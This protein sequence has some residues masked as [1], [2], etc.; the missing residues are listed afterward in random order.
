MGAVALI[1]MTGLILARRRRARADS[2]RELDQR[3]VRSAMLDIVQGSG[4]ATARLRPFRRQ[5]R[6]MSETLLEFLAIVRGGEKAALVAAFRSL[7]IDD[8]IRH[9][10]T[11]GGKQGRTLA[12]EAI[13]AFPGPETVD[14]LQRL[15]REDRDPEVRIAAVRSLIALDAPPTL[16]D[17][18]SD[19]RIRGVS[20]SLLYLPVVLRMTRLDPEQALAL[21]ADPAISLTARTLIA[22]ALGECGD[23]RAVM[24]LC[25]AASDA[26]RALRIAAVRGLGVL[27]HPAAAAAIVQALDDREWE[28]RS[29]AC[30]AAG[31]IGLTEALP[32]LVQRLTDSE[33][34]V[35]FQAAEAMTRMGPAGLARLRAAAGDDIDVMRRAASMALAENGLTMEP[36]P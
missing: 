27:A 11:R 3:Q 24:P 35:R 17:L 28:V 22:G 25:E 30:E 13:A 14:V 34:W 9:R 10:L 7:N 31:R 29:A 18:I 16:R 19:L 6:L 12:A 32:G 1:W 15:M 20:D 5:A 21:F 33:W 26:D 8:R 2:R 36:A 4:D 23:Y